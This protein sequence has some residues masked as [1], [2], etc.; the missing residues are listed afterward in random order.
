MAGIPP[1]AEDLGCPDGKAMDQAALGG[2]PWAMNVPNDES[3][4]MAWV[5]CSPETLNGFK[6]RAAYLRIWAATVPDKCV[7][8][9][10]L[11]WAW[12]VDY[13][14]DKA[15]TEMRTHSDSNEYKRY[16]TEEQKESAAVDR[17]APGFPKPSQQ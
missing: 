11:T 4:S 5:D 12:Y 14:V 3:C 9:A 15:E 7:Q 10:Y 16:E 8:A 2:V 13:E 6:Q 1:S 17:I